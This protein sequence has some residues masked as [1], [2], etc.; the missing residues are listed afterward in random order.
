LAD[1]KIVLKLNL[2]IQS[3]LL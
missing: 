2:V 1:S 3:S